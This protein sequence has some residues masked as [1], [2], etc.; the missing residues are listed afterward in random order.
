MKKLK[1]VIA[2][3]FA[4]AMPI[5]A[6]VPAL[7]DD[8]APEKPAISLQISPVSNRI[9]L[10]HGE[11]ANYSMNVDNI[12][13]DEFN[14]RVYA[15][16]YTVANEN[17]DI[18]F[19]NETKRTQI[20][21]WI[22]FKTDAGDY[23]SEA[24]FKLAP[25]ERKTVEYKV[26]VPEDVP[27]GGQ[28]A[29]VFAETVPSGNN[30]STGIRT[31]SRVGLIIYGRTDGET[32]DSA[33]IENTEIQAFMTSGDI[34]VRSHIVNDGNTDFQASAKLTVK[35]FFGKEL[36]TQTKGFDVLP[37]TSRNISVNWEDTP[38][39]GLFHVSAEIKALDQTIEVSKIVVVMPVFIIVIMAILL[40]IL[41]VWIII[42]VKKRRS[43][44]SRLNV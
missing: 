24:T 38:V 1:L 39:M 34:N 41:I 43:Q 2:A 17:Y 42:L 5:A 15:A 16:P 31:I 37:D 32:K 28:Y 4:L 30:Q 36:S 23:A 12:G 35:G 40:T 19:S 33:K 9:F 26:D 13:S 8:K 44:R 29:T 21:R 10:V 25:G 18:N 7:A 27:G 6:T 22:T 14:F 3:L 11:S 20:T